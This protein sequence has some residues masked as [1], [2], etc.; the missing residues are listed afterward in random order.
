VL[1][2]SNFNFNPRLES[3]IHVTICMMTWFT[4]RASQRIWAGVDFI[5]VSN[6]CTSQLGKQRHVLVTQTDSHGIRNTKTF[7]SVHIPVS[8]SE[9]FN[10][11]QL[12]G[13]CYFPFITYTVQSSCQLRQLSLI[14][15]PLFAKDIFFWSENIKSRSREADGTRT[16]TRNNENNKK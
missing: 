12:L 13:F 14:K 5:H 6:Q 15:K 2:K 9:D 4:S 16:S 3:P 1:N 7:R 11:E 8:C 10:Q